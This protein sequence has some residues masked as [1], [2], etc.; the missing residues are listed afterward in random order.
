MVTFVQGMYSYM[1]GTI[2]VARV[3]SVA[4]SLWLQYISHD[5]RFAVNSINIV[6]IIIS[7]TVVG[8]NIIVITYRGDLEFLYLACVCS[9]T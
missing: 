6:I 2:C 8:V 5:K 4:A 3:D 9:R 1:L 7:M